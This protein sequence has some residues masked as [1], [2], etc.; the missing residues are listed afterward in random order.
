[1]AR[2]LVRYTV[3]FGVHRGIVEEIDPKIHDKQPDGASAYIHFFHQD[4]DYCRTNLVPTSGMLNHGHS[5]LRMLS[6]RP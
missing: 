2:I 5:K 1:L 6:G 3:G 4:Y